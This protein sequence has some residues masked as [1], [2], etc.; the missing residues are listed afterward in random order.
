MRNFAKQNLRNFARK[1]ILHFRLFFAFSYERNAKNAKPYSSNT[2]DLP[3][4]SRIPGKKEEY[5]IF[6]LTLGQF[7]TL[8]SKL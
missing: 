5:Y 4:V 1:F 2:T 3:V 8:K 6:E 7:I